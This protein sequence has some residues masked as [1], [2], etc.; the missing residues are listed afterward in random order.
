[1]DD[2]VFEKAKDMI[3]LEKSIFLR[4]IEHGLNF[5]HGFKYNEFIGELKLD[6]WEKKVAD[7]YF[8]AANLNSRSLNQTI[9]A[10]NIE[11]PFLLVEIGPSG[12]YGDINH[13]YI[14][15]YDANFKYID[16]QELKFARRT[17]REAR[18]FSKIAI[19]ISVVAFF[20]SILVPIFIAKYFT[21]TIKLEH[22]QL[23][24]FKE[25]INVE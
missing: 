1:M 24:F 10:S 16:Y 25:S 8:K 19:V 5:P 13:T 15:S 7:E 20:A 21:Q 9:T 18:K 6:G 2:E 14:I 23:E 17:A 3:N 22:S 4:I 12:F 11:T